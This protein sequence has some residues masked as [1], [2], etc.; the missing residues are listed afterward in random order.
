MLDGPSLKTAVLHTKEAALR[1]SYFWGKR[2]AS[3]LS[4]SENLLSAVSE[5]AICIHGSRPFP[6]DGRVSSRVCS[7]LLRNSCR[8][9]L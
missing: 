3:F 4:S 1:S 9:G 6:D 7:P 8:A 2:K 5:N